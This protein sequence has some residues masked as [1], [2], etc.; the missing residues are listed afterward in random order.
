VGV[1]SGKRCATGFP[2]KDSENFVAENQKIIGF[3]G[4]LAK[5]WS[6]A[7]TRPA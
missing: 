2:G 1:A 7:G 6:G 3:D 5:G 4:H